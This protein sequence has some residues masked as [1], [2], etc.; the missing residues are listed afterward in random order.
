MSRLLRYIFLDLLRTRFILAYTAF[1]MLSTI[2]LYQ[3]DTD[4]SK[5]VLSLMNV[6]LIVAPLVSIIFTT[7]H[8]YN[9]Y[10]FMELMLTQ[11]I[12][13]TVVIT[14][15]YLAVSSALCLAF[16]VGLGLPMVYYGADATALT[17][18]G[19]G[20]LLTLVF[21]SLALMAS[22]LTRDKARAIGLALMFWFYFTLIYDAFVLWV[23][24]SFSEYPLEYPT[25][26]MTALNPVDLARILMILQ[27]DVSALMGYTGAFYQR[28]FGSGLG[29][30]LSLAVLALWAAVPLGVT[31][32]LFSRKDI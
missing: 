14:A 9:S 18:L 12:G 6:L 27:L 16:V 22:V 23:L 4:T 2:S 19:A 5:V 26:I 21:S 31:L 8:Y 3:L 7:I 32:R 30:G 1:L 20:V 29:M 13:R 11:P 15:Q 28:L 25:L 10:E 24:Y 17:L